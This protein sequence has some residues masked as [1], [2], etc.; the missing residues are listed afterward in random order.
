VRQRNNQTNERE[1]IN[2]KKEKKREKNEQNKRPSTKR[3]EE[4]K[5]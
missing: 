2:G 1:T 4:Q 5:N 3:V